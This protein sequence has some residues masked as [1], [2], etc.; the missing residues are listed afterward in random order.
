MRQLYSS[1]LR[2]YLCLGVLALIGIYS[3]SKLPVSLFPNSAKPRIIVNFPYGSTTAPEF[4]NTD[5]N[6]LESKLKS[7][8]TDEVEVEKVS[9]HYKSGEARY[10]VEFKWGSQPKTARKEVDAIVQTFAGRYP[11][12]VRQGIQT[13]AV[14]QNSG[15]FSMSFYS[16]K[17]SLDEIYNELEPIL[18]PRIAQVRDA[19]TSV[20]WNPNEK[21]VRIELSPERM[22]TLGLVPRQIE[23]AINSVLATENGGSLTVGTQSLAI[24]MPRLASNL[25]DLGH[26]LILTPSGQTVQLS[27]VARIDFG[28]VTSGANSFRTNGAPSLIL[29]SSPRAG[30][31][32]KRM[33]EDILKIVDDLAPQFS[34]DIRYKVLV[35][36]SEFIRG[37]VQNV[38]KE[39]AIGACLAVAIL[40]L[41][42]GS[43]R[44]TV[45][46]AI[47]IPLSMIMAFIL[48]KFSGMNLNLI[49]LGGLALSAG[50]NVD[51]SVVVMENI[52]RHFEEYR[53]KC[54]SE[55]NS[56]QRLEILLRA[57]AEVRFP[58]IASTL[59]SLVVFVPLAFTSDLSYAILGDLAKTV[60]F[61]H[62][63]SAFVALILVPTV[64]LQLMSGPQAEL[65]ISSPIEAK[66]LRLEEFYAKSLDKVLTHKKLRNLLY[67]GSALSLVLLLVL[68]LPHLPR[69][70]IGKPDTDWMVV[71]VETQGNK[72]I[73]QMETY[74][75][76]TEAR[77]L[78]KFGDKILYT[79]NQIWSP[80][81]AEVMARLRDKHDMRQVQKQME[82]LFTN[83]PTE[84]Y[85]IEAWNPAEMHI[86]DPPDFKVVVQSTRMSDRL[87]A[88][89]QIQDI[90]QSSNFYDRVKSDPSAGR[91]EGV[92]IKPRADIW[93]AMGKSGAKLQLEDVADIS[94]VATEGRRVGQIDVDG[95][96]TSIFMR[97]PENL[98]N[99]V[100]DLGA[101]PIGIGAKLVPLRALADVSLHNQ[102]PAVY[103]QN[104]RELF[105]ITGRLDQDR[106]GD[107]KKIEKRAIAA[108]ND[109]KSKNHLPVG[110]LIE[111]AKIE[112]TDALKQLS[113]AVAI[114]I[115][116]MFLTLVLQ[117]G[118]LVDAALVLVAVPL[119][120]I[121]VLLSLIVFRSTL[122]L[123]SVLGVI[124]LNGI[125]VANSIILV[126]FLKKR[127]R[128]GLSPRAAAID[129]GK[130]RLRPILI[131]SMTTILGMMP[132]ALGLGDGGRILQPLGIAVSGGLWV[133]M[134]LTLLIVPS[135]QVSWL[136]SRLK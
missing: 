116:L 53:E 16:D 73:G 75:A 99:T 88:A 13:R 128:D 36:P 108:V 14:N 25:D 126:D 90:L 69:E 132:I 34:K 81:G 104:G 1:P 12:E 51:A 29:W 7:I 109:W 59:A 100:E 38:M 135:L 39:V 131:T 94:R 61:S 32:V 103:R 57:V 85:G 115:G 3:G 77:V 121:G 58:V 45:T 117:F 72:V 86:P 64:R 113:F 79:F 19:E 55:L 65:Q 33:S 92:E 22:A 50:M 82:E 10:E 119:G 93:Q 96:N 136:E 44:N 87:S 106:L 5:G 21:E 133:S 97:Y 11:L 23:E 52:F 60:V 15:F 70:I 46:A 125:A 48:M 30:G 68:G 127:V 123:N 4:L 78:E 122:S 18:T 28:P 134:L 63:L 17:R 62:G 84:S 27:D 6:A 124:L 40:F 20:L 31:N 66:L 105:E 114:S 26:A 9:A 91:I 54:A 2:V 95:R 110:V 107:S 80:N 42:I 8:V 49:S 120:L 112:L 98:L 83:T 129:A 130:K 101:M 74:A 67:G 102:T 118:S 43:F 71:D 37:S 41:F 111:D 24:Q 76:A 89:Q 47:E 35:D 56:A